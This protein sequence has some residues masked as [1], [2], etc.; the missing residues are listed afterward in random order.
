MS[1]VKQTEVEQTGIEQAEANLADATKAYR[2]LAGFAPNPM[3]QA[4]WE[5]FVQESPLGVGLLLKGPTGSGKTESVSVPALNLP[6]LSQGRRL[7]MIYPTR[8]LVDDQTVRFGEMLCRLSKINSGRPAVLNIDTGT[9]MERRLWL[10]GEP[11]V[12]PGNQR[13][14]LYQGNVIITTLDKF[15][16]RFFGFGEPQKSYTY[17]LRIHHLRQPLFCFDEAHSYND[18]AFTN[19]SR[20]VRT[21]YERNLDVVLMTATMPKEKA[22]PWFDFLERCDFVT[23]ERNRE[24][25]ANCTRS[26]F[27]ARQYPARTLQL[28]SAQVEEDEVHESTLVERLVEQSLQHA[29]PDR[30]IIIVIERVQDAVETWRILRGHDENALLYH[31]RLTQTRRQTVYSKLREREQ[32]DEGY[33]LVTTSAIEVGCDLDAHVL[34]TQL[35]D[36]DRLVQRAGRCNRRQ[37]M[38]DA[39]VIVVGDSIPSWL[40][41]LTE[42]EWKNYEEALRQQH[43]YTLQ[44]VPLLDCM[45]S[46]PRIDQ[47]V[48]MMFDMLSEYVYDA[49]L[50]NKPLHEKG[51]I[52]TR[53]WEPSLTLCTE[54]DEDGRPQNAVS[55]PIRSCVAK[56]DESLAADWCVQTR[57]YDKRE[58][59]YK[60]TPLSGMACAYFVDLIACPMNSTLFIFD[61]EEGWVDVPNLFNFSFERGNRRMVK[62]E[63]GNDQGLLWYLESEADAGID[64][65]AG[66]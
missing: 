59:K 46:E 65:L 13:R 34:I 27:P 33:L 5:H 42:E 44:P 30:R 22:T 53:S 26:T 49:V 10:N 25:L 11:Q 56:K 39:K 50:E 66:K 20:L 57:S 62:R 28:V 24:A 32:N 60:E 7:V 38:P 63:D 12:V 55:V 9:Q 45:Q 29:Q 15:L 14:H 48:E 31:G 35:C 40:T 2:Q 37:Q 41:A 6:S 18:V 52:V 64:A 3:Q 36:P 54:I 47:R 58:R 23:D 19:F 1:L 4:V 51:L 61:E 16:Y 8:S 21:L 17:P 43:S